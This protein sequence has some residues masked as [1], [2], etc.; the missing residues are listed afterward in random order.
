MDGSRETREP[1]DVCSLVRCILCAVRD[2]FD[3][4]HT[5][6]VYTSF[7][8]LFCSLPRC[9]KILR[10]RSGHNGRNKGF[11]RPTHTRARARGIGWQ[12]ERNGHG[13][14]YQRVER[15]PCRPVEYRLIA[16]REGK[17]DPWRGRKVIN[18]TS[19]EARL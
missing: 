15:V 2:R 16:S 4:R 7:S 13:G 1:L 14:K 12:K 5:A 10:R 17:L 3:R 6:S 11:E 18:L 19:Y 8:F 9:E